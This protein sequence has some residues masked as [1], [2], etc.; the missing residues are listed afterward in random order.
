M[1]TALPEVDQN[2]WGV[3]ALV[4]RTPIVLVSALY[5]LV[6]TRR[7]DQISALFDYTT[8]PHTVLIV[9]IAILSG[10]V[11]LSQVQRGNAVWRVV[12]ALLF[13]LPSILLVVAFHEFD[14]A[15]TYVACVGALIS[16]AVC[17]RLQGIVD[18]NWKIA[19]VV[20]LVTILLWLSLFIAVRSLPITFPR[21]FGS[22]ALTLTFVAFV[23]VFF[24]L[25]LRYPALGIPIV[26]LL[27]YLF[28]FQERP[29]QIEQSDL[30]NN[31]SNEEDWTGG[32]ASVSLQQAFAVWLASRNDLSTYRDSGNPYPVFLV[33]SEGGG[34]YA[35]AHADL[36]L[37]KV[38][39]RCPN[40][41]QHVFALVGVSGGS[42]GNS[43]FW[44][45]L[46]DEVN[47]SESKGCTEVAGDPRAIDRLS[48]DN[49]S[50][51]LAALYF[52]DFPNKFW[53][54]FGERDRADALRA[55]LVESIGISPDKTNPFYWQHH[56]TEGPSDVW[57]MSDKPAVIDVATNL[58]SGK[59]YVFAPFAFS[60]PKDRFEESLLDLNWT[61][62]DEVGPRS[63]DIRFMD[64]AI[65][66]ASFP[67]VTPS[68]V[69]SGRLLEQL[70]LV[71]GGYIDNSGA[72]TARDI[73]AEL[74]T[75]SIDFDGA[76]IT[77]LKPPR[78]FKAPSPEPDCQDPPR[79]EPVANPGPPSEAVETCGIKFNV[80]VI[81]IR[82]EVPY[83][84]GVSA[85]NFFLDP[86]TSILNARSRRGETARYA[87][88]SQ[89]CGSYNCAP[90]VELASDWGLHES[91]IRTDDLT[92]PLGWFLPKER[93]ARL[94]QMVAPKSTE[95]LDVPE[96]YHNVGMNS[97][98]AWQ[99][100]IFSNMSKNPQSMA[101]IEE[102]LKNPTK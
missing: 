4:D 55:S 5:L 41:A 98:I 87:L 56:W 94:A 37:S 72:E 24:Q 88:L 8:I 81:A 69:I 99:S 6:A 1:T 92:L 36:F 49:L 102:V 2:I 96:I 15:A 68:R 57:T 76:T 91:V 11:L 80:H 59:R 9:A 64:A 82:A 61:G 101:A 63:S 27:C 93:V 47:L 31:G 66:S 84:R 97:V 40:F 75:P 33:T 73:L 23:A 53:S 30:T 42:V 44:A 54:I 13:S 10:V 46:T 58:V 17:F 52:K 21:E 65:A 67:Y 86:I 62:P 95:V 22:V 38:Q 79:Y 71:D 7:G 50:P 29:H 77:A 89:L 20:A 3:R 12:D 78:S 70:A 83:N 16:I 25:A 85:Q 39:K 60:F 14:R 100:D 32:R 74:Q 34:G 48:T 43:T 28:L 26:A 18:A 35:A 90:Q 51:V 19:G 45:G